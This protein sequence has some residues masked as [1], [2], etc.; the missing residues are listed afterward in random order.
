MSIYKRYKELTHEIEGWFSTE[1]I[2]IWDSFLEFQKKSQLQGNIGEIGVWHGKS[3]LLA[4]MHLRKNEKMLLV[5]PRPMHEAKE[6]IKKNCPNSLCAFFEHTSSHLKKIEAYQN[7]AS[8]FRWFH[9][10]GE[11]SSQAAYLDLEIADYL[12]SEDGMIVV[13]DFFKPMYPQITAA[14]FKYIDSRPMRLQLILVGHGKGYIC[15][16]RIAKTY[17]SFIKNNLHSE[18]IE[19]GISNITIFKTT[20]PDDMNCFGIGDKYLDFNYRGPDWG[21]QR[22]IQI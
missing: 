20:S 19:R 14:V 8:S 1:S 2:G 22:M 18:M 10:D 21:D 9:I 11:H 6:V 4:A 3:A 12:L 13:D 17:L 16:P 7:S 5:D 15:R